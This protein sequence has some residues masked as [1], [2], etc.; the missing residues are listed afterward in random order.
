LCRFTHP[1]RSGRFVPFIDELAFDSDHVSA[2]R[3][4]IPDAALVA[5]DRDVVAPVARESNGSSDALTGL[6]IEAAHDVDGFGTRSE[7]GGTLVVTAEG[8]RFRG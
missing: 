5:V 8:R 3:R 1:V 7:N 4:A 2:P 6:Q